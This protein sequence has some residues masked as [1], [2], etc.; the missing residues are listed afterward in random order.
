MKPLIVACGLALSTT[1]SAIP[2]QAALTT[3][4][5]STASTTAQATPTSSFAAP[6]TSGSWLVFNIDTGEIIAEQAPNTHFDPA[7]LINV[8]LILAALEELDP[9]S[10]LTIAAPGERP[11][12]VQGQAYSVIELVGALLHT[13]ATDAALALQAA[14]EP[15][16]QQNIL[17]RVG[18][19]NTTL[20]A[21]PRTTA[22]DLALLY[23][24]A[25]RLPAYM[26]IFSSPSVQITTTEGT[27]LISN[28]NAYFLSDPDSLGGTA[29]L[30]DGL[31]AFAGAQRSDARL[32]VVMLGVDPAVTMPSYQAMELFAAAQGQAPTGV[33]EAPAVEEVEVSIPEME[34]PSSPVPWLGLGAM[35]LVVLGA[36]TWWLQRRLPA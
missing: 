31:Y 34:T 28:S 23:R 29:G 20:G 26:Q 24:Y 10:E 16:A 36:A 2:A 1:L 3:T 18:A 35:A 9:T 32:G 17:E 14:I 8:T 4:A 7:T 19:T 33:L 27:T 6:F 30:S 25:F 11:M 15:D 13:D 12:L 22:H 5:T 21:N